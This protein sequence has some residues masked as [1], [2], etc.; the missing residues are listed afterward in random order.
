MLNEL[1]GR[2]VEINIDDFGT[3]YSNL[4]YLKKLPVSAI[5]IDRSFVN[6]IDGEGNNDDLVRAI[7]M[8]SRNLGLLVIAEGVEQEMQLNVLRDYGCDYAQGF[9]FAPPMDLAHLTDF[10]NTQIPRRSLP[11][12][13]IDLHPTVQ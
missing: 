10:L 1:K 11:S 13:E 8:L 4:G 12:A 2:G 7:I 9:Y 5:K 3:G 6:M